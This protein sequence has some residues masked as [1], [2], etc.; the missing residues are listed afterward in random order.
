MFGVDGLIA[1]GLGFLGQR[2]TNRENRHMASAQMQFQE[3]MSNTQWQR[4]VEDMQA[5]GLNPM[6]AYSQGGASAPPGASAVM[7]SELGAGVSSARE[8]SS[9]KAEVE[10]KQA[11][12]ETQRQEARKV[13]AQ[14]DMIEPVGE[15]VSSG[16]AAL[17]D[18][19]DPARRALTDVIEGTVSSFSELKS[20]AAGVRDRAVRGTVETAEAIRELIKGLP[21]KAKEAFFSSAEQV[22]RREE[23]KR[24]TIPGTA[25]EGRKHRGTMR[26]KL[27]GAKTWDY[28]PER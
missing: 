3:R 17:K 22:K 15:A 27:G 10:L 16:G 24:A 18:L 23:L 7:G 2:E 6:L 5:A 9:A 21:E 4:G 20:S 28:G 11:Q 12:A 26:G 13:K 1:G 14:A 19:A 8:Y 25:G